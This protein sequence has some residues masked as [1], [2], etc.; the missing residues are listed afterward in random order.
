MNFTKTKSPLLKNDINIKNFHLS[1]LIVL[2]ICK[3]IVL[4]FYDS[5]FYMYIH[6]TNNRK[7]INKNIKGKTAY[8]NQKIRCTAVSACC[9]QG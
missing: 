4:E 8:K 2:L 7:L 9:I 3:K 5:P 6:K 1:Q